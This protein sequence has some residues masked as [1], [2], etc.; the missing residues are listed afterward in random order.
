VDDREAH[1]ILG[2][3]PGATKNEIR[4]AYLR[5]SH[6]VHADAGG[7]DGLFR[8][9]KLAYDTLV[10]GP[11][12]RSHEPQG[13]WSEWY[14]ADDEDDR[15]TRSSSDDDPPSP[16]HRWVR[17]NP[18]VTLLLAGVTAFFVG[19]RLGPGAPIITLF[20][21]LAS[22]LG[23]AGLLGAKETRAIHRFEVGGALLRRQLRAGIPRLLK[24][25]GRTVLVAFVALL[26]LGVAR[27]HSRKVR[28]QR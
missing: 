10:D 19:V 24:A 20:A 27:D 2:V 15:T 5:L 6:Q 12:G 23:L 4:H 7:S 8:Q 21:V 22:L 26:A 13:T 16:L 9:V 11:P 25:V 17:A 14:H 1:D 28:H 3:A 18:S